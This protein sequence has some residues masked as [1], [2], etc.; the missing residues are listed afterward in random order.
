MRRRGEEFV[1]PF[2]L[3]NS[4]ILA[5]HSNNNKCGDLLSLITP[6]TQKSLTIMVAI[7]NNTSSSL[8]YT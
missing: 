5:C 2:I 6:H 1:A 3:K 7:D 8:T 4:C